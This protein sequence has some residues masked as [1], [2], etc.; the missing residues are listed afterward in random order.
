[1]IKVIIVILFVFNILAC[2]PVQ[3]TSQENNKQQQY[4]F[5]CLA[6]QSRCEVNTDVGTFNI[7]FS[8]QVAMGKVKTELPFQIQLK[9]NAKAK[10][11]QLT[12]VS[13]YLE[14]KTMFMGKVPVFF[15]KTEKSSDLM[16]AE[17][18]LANCSEK[19]MA[20]R[21]WFTVEVE[22]AATQQSFF[23]DFD[24]ERL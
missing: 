22:Q 10:N 16:V 5:I 2:N 3:Q 15:Q 6:S 8:G 17:S 4:P 24:S 21:L 23:I 11:S 14:G 13:S 20:W 9:F 12:K 19:V 7:Q 18:L 1:M